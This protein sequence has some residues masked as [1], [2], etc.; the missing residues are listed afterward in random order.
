MGDKD[1]SLVAGIGYHNYM[2]VCEYTISVERRAFRE[3]H[4]ECGTHS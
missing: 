4:S 1:H 2:R 3:N